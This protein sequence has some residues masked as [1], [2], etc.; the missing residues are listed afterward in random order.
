MVVIIVV[1]RLQF[2]YI[3]GKIKKTISVKNNLVYE[4]AT[5]QAYK[6]AYKNDGKMAIVNVVAKRI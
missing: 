1:R 4:L 5:Q 2:I 3:L 6:N